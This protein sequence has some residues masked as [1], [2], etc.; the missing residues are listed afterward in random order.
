MT[1]TF[2]P[3]LPS[4]RATALPIP[5]AP[6]VTRAV[7]LSNLFVMSGSLSN[8]TFTSRGHCLWCARATPRHGYVLDGH[9]STSS[10]VQVP[11][12]H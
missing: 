4:A 6:P 8:F 5:D 9:K 3:S 11:A 2:A 7:Y 10:A 1:K 12:V